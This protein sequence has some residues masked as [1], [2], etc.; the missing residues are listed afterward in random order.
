MSSQSTSVAHQDAP[1]TQR[2]LDFTPSASEL[3]HEAQDRETACRRILERLE[4]GPATTWEMMQ[5][6]GSGFSSRI[7]ELR[8]E[9]RKR[10]RNIPPPEKHGRVYWYR[11]VE[12]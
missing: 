5:L 10:G 2:R 7:N 3:Q 4:S 1:G 8:V 6:G 9:L 11:L 12:V